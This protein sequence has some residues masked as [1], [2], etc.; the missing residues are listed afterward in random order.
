MKS[1]A[2]VFT[3]SVAPNHGVPREHI[4]VMYHGEYVVSI[5]HGS[6]K[7]DDCEDKVL[8][9]VRVVEWDTMPNGKSMDL[10]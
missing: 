5:G 1:R 9:H 10:P 2:G 3:F 8:A 7:G 4:G 6:R